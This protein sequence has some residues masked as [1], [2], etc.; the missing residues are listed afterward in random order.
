MISGERSN[1]C[2]GLSC[3][4]AI[5]LPPMAAHAVA[6]SGLVSNAGSGAAGS[7]IVHRQRCLSTCHSRAFFPEEMLNRYRAPPRKAQETTDSPLSWNAATCA[8]EASVT[9]S[10]PPSSPL[11]KKPPS[12]LAASA[13]I[14]LE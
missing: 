4:C 11:A 9:M 10:A 14:S 6:P 3:N 12:G 5:R 8:P 13:V 1:S 7:G 2:A